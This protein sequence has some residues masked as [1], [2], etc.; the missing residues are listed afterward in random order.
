MVTNLLGSTQALDSSLNTIISEFRLLTDFPTVFESTA[1]SFILL[2]HEGTSKLINN[3]ARMV[4][5]PVADGAD[6]SQVQAL[7][8]ATN[9]YTPGEVAVQTWLPGSTMRRIA[10]PD[11]LARTSKILMNALNLREDQDGGAQM[12]NWSVAMGAT[13][14]I[15]GMGEYLGGV[16]R[17]MVGNSLANPEPAP[18]PLWIVDHPIKLTTL[19]GKLVPLADVPAGTNIYTPATATTGGVVAPGATPEGIAA[20]R[21]GVAA[22]GQLF[23]VTV[24]RSANTTIT[25][26]NNMAGGIYSQEGLIY[27]NEVAKRLD[28]DDSDKSYRGALELNGWTSYVWGVYRPGAFGIETIGDCTLPAS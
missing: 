2:P 24:K 17:L 21:Q 15:M 13:S 10:D 20:L 27:V 1:S 7:A 14:R 18:E 25:S 23:G 19:I 6:I 26:A 12:V 22:I 5:S 3:Y 4:A 9:T 16:M 8:D 28:P 11:L